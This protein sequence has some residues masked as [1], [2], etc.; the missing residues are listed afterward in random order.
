MGKDKDLQRQLTQLMIDQ[1]KKN[2]EPNPNME[3][4]KNYYQGVLDWSLNPHNTVKDIKN[5]PG[6]GANL[7]IYQLSKMYRDNGRIGQGVANLGNRN[8][9]AYMTDLNLERDLNKS[10]A[11]A[12]GLETAIQGKLDSALSGLQNVV[13]AD[14]SRSTASNSLMQYMDQALT[15]R[16][17][18]GWNGFWS[19]LA[20]GGLQAGMSFAT[21]GLS[22]LTKGLSFFGGG[23]S[24]TAGA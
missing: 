3:A 4:L 6:I 22:N 5:M 11:A 7:P 24:G 15:Q 20:R 14:T 21:G 17:Q 18:G 12:G 23:G 2:N 10:Q 13:M 19:G 9:S 16:R 1:I 8:D